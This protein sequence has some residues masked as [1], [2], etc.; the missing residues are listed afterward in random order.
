MTEADGREAVCGA[1]VELIP[2]AAFRWLLAPPTSALKT[3][4]AI[5][6]QET[7]PSSSDP[8]SSLC[9]ASQSSLTFTLSN[10]MP[11]SLHVDTDRHCFERSHRLD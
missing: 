8:A 5:N 7:S 10:S 3:Q 6:H 2:P 9:F 4:T 11:K 1:Q